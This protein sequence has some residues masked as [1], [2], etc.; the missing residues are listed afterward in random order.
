MYQ[1]AVLNDGAHTPNYFGNNIEVK[2]RLNEVLPI[3]SEI[4]EEERV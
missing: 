3:L 1:E 2:L 4:Y